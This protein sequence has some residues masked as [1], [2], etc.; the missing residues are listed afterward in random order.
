[1]TQKIRNPATYLIAGF[2]Y[3]AWWAPGESNPAP[4]DYESRALNNDLNNQRIAV[5]PLAKNL[6]FQPYL[7]KKCSLICSLENL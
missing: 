3:V 4:T 7:A 2:P 6:D 1:M 5:Y